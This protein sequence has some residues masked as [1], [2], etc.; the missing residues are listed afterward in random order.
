MVQSN[1]LQ[2][3]GPLGCLQEPNLLKQK[4]VGRKKTA[5]IGFSRDHTT[6]FQI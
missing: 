1:P 5:G 2:P 6:K 4:E 3:Q